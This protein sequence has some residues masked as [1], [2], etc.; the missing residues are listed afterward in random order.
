MK[1]TFLGHGLEKG[2]KFNVGKQIAISLLLLLF[3]VF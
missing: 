1:A 3:Q 2:D